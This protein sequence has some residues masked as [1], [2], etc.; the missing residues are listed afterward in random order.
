VV[1]DEC[2]A[3]TIV[4]LWRL[5]GTGLSIPWTRLGD[6]GW[7]VILTRLDLDTQARVLGESEKRPTYR[8]RIPG[9]GIHLAARHGGGRG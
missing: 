5:F 8:D 1:V 6:A 7:S 3:D 9:G 4:S 2:E